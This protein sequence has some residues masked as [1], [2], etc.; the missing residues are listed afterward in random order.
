MNLLLDRDSSEISLV[1]DEY[2][3]DIDNED[4]RLCIIYE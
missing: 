2:I 1:V 4:I 3:K